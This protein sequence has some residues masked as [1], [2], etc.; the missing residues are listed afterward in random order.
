MIKKYTNEKI[1]I[2][3][4]YF[5]NHPNNYQTWWNIQSYITY[6]FIVPFKVFMESSINVISRK[7]IWMRF[8]I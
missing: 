4:I 5:K 7:N 2:V 1:I 6:E 8:F 3:A